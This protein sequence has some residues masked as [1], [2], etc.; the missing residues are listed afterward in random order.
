MATPDTPTFPLRPDNRPALDRIRY[1]LGTYPDI[2]DAMLRDLKQL[3]ERR[4]FREGST[5]T[6]GDFVIERAFAE[7]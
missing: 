3:L 5:S 6:P 7:Q 1:R 4:G 2:L